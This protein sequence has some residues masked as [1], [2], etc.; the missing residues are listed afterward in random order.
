MSR[1]LVDFYVEEAAPAGFATYTS[2]GFYNLTKA[3]ALISATKEAS[4]WFATNYAIADQ[5]DAIERALAS[6]IVSINLEYGSQKMTDSLRQVRQELQD[7]ISG[8]KSFSTEREFHD[9]LKGTL[10]LIVLGS[11]KPTGFCMSDVMRNAIAA[12]LPEEKTAALKTI[13]EKYMT[14]L[15]DMAYIRAT[16][17][18]A[19]ADADYE[20]IYTSPS[21]NV[22]AMN[23][24][25][26]IPIPFFVDFTVDELVEAI[27][28][29]DWEKAEELGHQ[30]LEGCVFAS[31]LYGGTSLEEVTDN[32]I[33]S[34]FDKLT[35]WS[36]FL[37]KLQ[38]NPSFAICPDRWQVNAK[39]N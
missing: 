11:S 1:K 19:K 14:A 18:P 29:D 38:F 23:S 22:F 37:K 34:V 5:Q 4:D 28:A 8:K 17:K 24:E 31:P 15:K 35:G 12:N 2:H 10:Y 26:F 6:S 16:N 25:Y 32:Y 36:S 9:F 20:Y 30:L 27:Q 33:S 13:Y 7:V 3:S 39:I 21:I